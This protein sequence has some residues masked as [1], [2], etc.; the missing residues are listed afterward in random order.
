MA[1]NPLELVPKRK[2][3]RELE[4]AV[5]G[6]QLHADVSIKRVVRSLLAAAINEDTDD[7]TLRSALR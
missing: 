5:E 3:K 4:L 7:F 6:A 1:F 2:L